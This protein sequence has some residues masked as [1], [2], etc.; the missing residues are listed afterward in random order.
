MRATRRLRVIAVTRSELAGLGRLTSLDL[1]YNRIEA[2]GPGGL[3]PRVDKVLLS[4]NALRELGSLGLDGPCSATI[5][6]LDVRDNK[7][8]AVPDSLFYCAGLKF[9]ELSNNNIGT[10][11]PGLGYLPALQSLSASVNRMFVVQLSMWSKLC[12]F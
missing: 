3:P 6:V 9:L 8:V 12:F 11:P 1:S 4:F 2:L 7:I 5:S 10:L